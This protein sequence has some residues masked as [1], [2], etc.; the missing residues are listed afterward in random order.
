MKKIQR[1]IQQLKSIKFDTLS[2]EQKIKFLAEM[3]DSYVEL[4]DEHDTVWSYADLLYFDNK[5][6]RKELNKPSFED[7]LGMQ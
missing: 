5:Q 6:L 4:L 3:L 2:E 1:Y 7:E